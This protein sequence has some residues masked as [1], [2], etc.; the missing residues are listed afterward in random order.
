M[1]NNRPIKS[2]AGVIKNMEMERVAKQIKFPKELVEAIEEHQKENMIP[3]FSAAV[4]E[5]VRK[6]LKS[7]EKEAHLK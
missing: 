5:L 3:T 7:E 4:Y 1:Y 2:R 6:G